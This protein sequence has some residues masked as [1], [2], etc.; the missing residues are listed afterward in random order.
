MLRACGGVT[1]D[2]DKIVINIAGHGVQDQH[3]SVDAFFPAEADQE[4]RVVVPHAR[5]SRH[6]CVPVKLL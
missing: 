4:G 5:G 3:F 1:G 6:N 2:K